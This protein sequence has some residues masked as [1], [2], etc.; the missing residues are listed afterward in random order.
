MPFARAAARSRSTVVSPMPR[1]GTLTT[2]SNAESAAGLPSRRRYAM[3]SLTSLRSKNDTAPTTFAGTRAA[4]RCSSSTR[5]CAFVRYRIAM[6]FGERGPS[7]SRR[8]I[9]CATKY[10]SPRSSPAW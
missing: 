1:A 6:S 10:A 9:D 4:R 7:S 3:T 5:D 2:R 8:R